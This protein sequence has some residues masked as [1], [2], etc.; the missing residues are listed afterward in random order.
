MPLM[1]LFVLND[2]I[3]NIRTGFEL[4]HELPNI[5]LFLCFKSLC[6]LHACLSYTGC[7]RRSYNVLFSFLK[8]IRLLERSYFC[9]LLGKGLI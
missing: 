3:M 6:K 1:C 2:L 4:V 9:L 5:Q 8:F 7:P